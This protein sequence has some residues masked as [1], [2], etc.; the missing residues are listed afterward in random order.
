M[1]N[2]KLFV[3]AFDK[4]L[5]QSSCW[6]SE[7]LHERKLEGENQTERFNKYLCQVWAMH[8]F[9]RL[10]KWIDGLSSLSYFWGKSNCVAFQS[11][12]EHTSCNRWNLM[13]IKKVYCLVLLLYLFAWGVWYHSRPLLWLFIIMMRIS[14]AIKCPSLLSRVCCKGKIFVMRFKVS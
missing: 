14:Q 6:G 9:C 8:K 10:R 1:E 5:N 12:V 13:S 11:H 7:R 2:S 4:H 3:W